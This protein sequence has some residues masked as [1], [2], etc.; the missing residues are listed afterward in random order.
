MDCPPEVGVIQ[1][2]KATAV[3]GQV[4]MSL[5]KMVSEGIAALTLDETRDCVEYYIRLYMDNT[6][7]P[8][9]P[10]TAFSALYRLFQHGYD[11]TKGA[12]YL[13]EDQLRE[14]LR[15]SLAAAFRDPN[16][17]ARLS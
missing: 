8:G 9:A 13:P 1:G 11:L 16:E 5:D 14:A 15:H 12:L 4:L 10:E 2:T 7:M 3:P 17:K 6:T